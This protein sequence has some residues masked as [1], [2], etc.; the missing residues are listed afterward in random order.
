[1]REGVEYAPTVK[2]LHAAKKSIVSTE[3]AD[4]SGCGTHTMAPSFYR[5]KEDVFGGAT[6]R[7]MSQQKG[8]GLSRADTPGP[9]TLERRCKLS[10]LSGSEL[11]DR[12]RAGREPL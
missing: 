9:Q 1:M 5:E 4:L 7:R 6:P 11:I 12:F 3:D 2:L 8:G 10:Q